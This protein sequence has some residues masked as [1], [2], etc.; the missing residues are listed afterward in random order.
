MTMTD[1]HRRHRNR[2]L[3]R[4]LDRALQELAD[5]RRRLWRA[6]LWYTVKAV[7]LAALAW[8]GWEFLT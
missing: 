5:R 2:Q 7:A 8:A 3:R 6:V 4:S 1:E